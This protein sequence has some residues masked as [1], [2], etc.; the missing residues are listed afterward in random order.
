MKSEID[1]IEM[2]NIQDDEECIDLSVECIN[3]SFFKKY[4]RY[5]SL[6]QSSE[7]SI[8]EEKLNNENNPFSKVN[9]DIYQYKVHDLTSEFNLT[10]NK[11]SN[12]S[13]FTLPKRKKLKKIFEEFITIGIEDDGLEYITDID[14][15]CLTPK[16]IYNFP[17]KL[18]ENELKL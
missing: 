8:E 17:N 1:G 16:I 10:S 13:K 15:L 18:N 7:G 12:N 9:T 6:S 14:E 3:E 5:S 4:G 2:H 11:S